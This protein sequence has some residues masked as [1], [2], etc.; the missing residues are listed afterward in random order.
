MWK[1]IPKT[2]GPTVTRS[3]EL[4]STVRD[5]GEADLEGLAWS[6]PPLHMASIA[7]QVRE[8]GAGGKDFLA[9]FLPTGHSVGKVEVSYD[10]QPDTG[11]VG[12]MS[13]RD[14]WQSLGVG[15]FLIGAAEQR[16]RERGLQGAALDVEENNPRARALHER[17]GYVAYDRRSDAWD[18]Q[19]PDGTIYRY[20]TICTLMRKD[21]P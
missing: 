1:G 18:Q 10:T 19:A 7:E 14:V 17:L 6:G 16:I 2:M 20:E 4:C 8:V 12:S 15:T 3:V 21:L 9:V 5:I 13:V 11:E